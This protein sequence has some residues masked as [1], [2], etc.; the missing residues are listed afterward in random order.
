MSTKIQYDP[1]TK[2]MVQVTKE[3]KATVAPNAPSTTYIVK[4]AEL[5]ALM[6]FAK[7]DGLNLN[8]NKRS[9]GGAINSYVEAAVNEFIASRKARS[10]AVKSSAP[11]PATQ[12]TRK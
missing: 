2:K 5:D 11:V 4:G 9:R 6:G 1:K 10:E 12:S 8:E 7:E 3:N